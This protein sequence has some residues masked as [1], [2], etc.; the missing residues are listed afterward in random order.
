MPTSS[1]RGLQGDPAVVISA[2]AF[3]LGN[4]AAPPSPPVHTPHQ[5]GVS[6]IVVSE[7]L[8]PETPSRS[9]SLTKRPIQAAFAVL[10]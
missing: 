6:S 10:P 1:A 5:G 9:I 8:Q 2:P 4:P 7:Q 3:D